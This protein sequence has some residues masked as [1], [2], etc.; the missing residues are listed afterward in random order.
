[1]L[2]AVDAVADADPE[3]IEATARRL[4]SS[5]RILAPVAWVAAMLVLV[6]RGIKLLFSN[7]RLL[8]L[9]LVPATWVWLTLWD[10]RK[11]GLRAPP[12][13]NVTP[14]DVLLAV[15]VAVAFSIAALW[16]NCVFGFAISLPEPRVRP[17]VRA[18]WPHRWRLLAAGFVVG[19]GVAA[20]FALIPRLDQVWVYAGAVWAMYGIMLSSLVVMPA[21]VIGIQRRRFGPIET[22]QRWVTGWALA[23][24]AMTPGFLVA[25][26]G[27]L[28]LDARR[29]EVL[30]YVVLTIGAV[31]YAAGLS[32]VKAVTLSMKLEIPDGRTV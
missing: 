7:W 8:A 23:A 5:R 2:Q 27:S 3:Q 17:G 1:M 29:F 19:T 15:S 18:T 13:R 14:E 4:G 20:C 25:R 32:S 24:V 28:L 6:V 9:E 21:W 16:C 30:G 10:L 22:V 11:Q 31:L 26:F 12:L